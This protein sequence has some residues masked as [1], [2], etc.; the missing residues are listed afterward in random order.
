MKEKFLTLLLIIM[1][2][3]PSASGANK[4]EASVPY[5]IKNNTAVLETPKREKGQKSALR[6]AVDPIKTVRIGFVGLGMRGAWAV[7]RFMFIDGIEVVALC[8][9]YPQKLEPMQQILEKNNRHRAAEYSGEDGWKDLCRRPD[10]DLVYIC[11]DWLTHVPMS[12]YAMEH[13]KHVAC[14]VPIATTIKDCWDLVNTAERTQRHCMM[15]ENCCYDFFEMTTLNMAQQGLFGDLVHVEGSYIHNLNSFWNEY[16]DNWRLLFNQANRG[17][18]YPTHGMGPACQLLNI[19][20]GDRMKTLVSVDTKSFNGIAAARKN[21]GA[22]S[23]ANGD[24]TI[25]LIR[26]EREKLLEIQ[27]N[28]YAERPYSRMYQLTGTEGFANKYPIEGYAFRNGNRLVAK[29]P[30]AG[31]ITDSE[32]FVNSELME[33]I[34]EAY[35]PQIFKDIEAKARKVGGHG[36]MD[37][38]MDYRLIYCLHNGLPLD[39]DVYDGVEWSCLGELSRISLE[40]GSIPVEVPD[41]TRGEWNKIKGFGYAVTK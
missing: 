6:L 31:S 4:Y 7:E 8:D 25:T 28:V 2:I 41:F 40:N 5:K 16:Q 12:V 17:D 21:M 36:G 23:F 32:T 13:G 33:K 3:A 1:M 30:E 39:E 14:E 37:Y 15:L 34:R 24:H 18:V 35:L 10:I 11:T 29:I 26:T 27:H 19:H 38:I 22:K 20:R 9:K